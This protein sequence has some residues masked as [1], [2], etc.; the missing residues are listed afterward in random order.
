VTSR[1]RRSSVFTLVLGSI[2]HVWLRLWP[3]VTDVIREKSHYTILPLES[4]NKESAQ[5][6]GFWIPMVKWCMGFFFDQNRA[7]WVQFPCL[8]IDT[9]QPEN[10]SSHLSQPGLVSWC[11]WPGV[12]SIARWSQ[13]PSVGLDFWSEKNPIT[14]FYHGSQPLGGRVMCE[15]YW[16]SVLMYT[17]GMSVMSLL[18][19]NRYESKRSRDFFL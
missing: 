13:K 16:L 6:P 7:P 3:S 17:L 10:K 19:K 5:I 4:R 11:A 12:K 1:V 8:Q 15:H 14:T 9:V 18:L 2:Y